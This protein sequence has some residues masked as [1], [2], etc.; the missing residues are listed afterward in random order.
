MKTA[1]TGTVRS[2]RAIVD[3]AI[4]YEIR[5]SRRPALFFAAIVAWVVASVTLA[6]FDRDGWTGLSWVGLLA[7]V[8]PLAG[9]TFSM[10]RAD[11]PSKPHFERNA[12]VSAQILE[13]RPTIAEEMLEFR[14]LSFDGLGFDGPIVV[15]DSFN[16]RVLAR[17]DMDWPLDFVRD[18]SN[19]RALL[20][21]LRRF[22]RPY[23]FYGRQA[24]LSSI[25][26]GKAL[27]NEGKVAFAAP[28]PPHGDTVRVFATD[29][30]MG[31]CTSERSLD[32]VYVVEHGRKQLRSDS[33]TR[34][35][36]QRDRPTVLRLPE[37]ANNTPPIS[38]HIGVELL[39]LTKDDTFRVPVQSRKTMWSREMRAPL[40]SGSADL[41]DLEEA[42]TLK[43]FIANAARRELAEEWGHGD[44][45]LTA[46]LHAASPEVI[47]YF[48][49]VIRCGKPQFVTVAR[50]D[51]YDDELSA[52]ES[53]VIALDEPV[54]LDTEK[55]LST[56]RNVRTVK[57][58]SRALE[59]ILERSN[60]HRDSVALLGSVHCLRSII[61]A[62]PERVAHILSLDID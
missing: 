29:Y 18:K 25:F 57:D 31:L 48:R 21:T 16:S 59:N 60:A 62:N 9:Y 10:L 47:G 12:S 56:F 51:C 7:L 15:S 43:A 28:F 41:G 11:A 19:Y 24:M 27:I 49:N 23:V 32:N 22:R 26:T 17:A 52:D 33:E 45:D 5:L 8:G 1:T 3:Y 37:V 39:A 46:R 50:L 58:L 36:F 53:E 2:L 55:S 30:F 20:R 6:L 34:L 54:Q 38:L 42:E 4:F 40:A 13:A 35:P 44:K 14:S 61:R